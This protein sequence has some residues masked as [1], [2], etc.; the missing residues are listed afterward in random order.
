MTT[1][2]SERARAAS[3]SRSRNSDDPEL[4]EAKRNMRALKLAEHV[5]R[6]VAQAPPLTAEQRERIVVLLRAGGGIA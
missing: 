4:L 6:V 3:L 2:T 5:A 1:W